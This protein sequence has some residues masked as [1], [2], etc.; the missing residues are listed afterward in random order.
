MV[1]EDLTDLLRAQKQTAWR[2][3]ARRI[4]HEIKNP[5]TPLVACRPSVFAAILIAPCLPTPLR[6]GIIRQ[7]A[8]TISSSV[9]T[10]RT[11]VDEFSTLAR[12]PAS[13]PQP[14]TSMPSS[15]KPR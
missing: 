2:E 15:T 4:A 9:E 1:L 12:F 13:K 5:L 7:C 6:C 3:V 14:P 11:L 10:V 8:I